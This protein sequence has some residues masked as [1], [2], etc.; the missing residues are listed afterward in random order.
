MQTAATQAA[1]IINFFVIK[2]SL[3][4]RSPNFAANFALARPLELATAGDLT[5]RLQ[6]LD[7][8]AQRTE[9]VTAV[10]GD[11]VRAP[12]RIPHPV[13]PQL[14]DQTRADQRVA[15]LVLDDVG[16]RAGRRRQRHVDQRDGPLL[17]F[18][19]V[20]TVDQAQVNDV[21]AEFGVDDIAHRLLDVAKQLVVR[22]RNFAHPLT[23]SK[24]PLACA[25]ASLN[26]IQPNS[27][28]FT[29]A[30]YFAT[31]ANATPSPSTSSSPAIFPRD[32]TI[33][34]NAVTVFSACPTLCPI[35]CSVSTDVAAWLIEQ[36]WPS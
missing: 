19:E 16:Q 24:S 13:D 11:L 34:V 8:E 29:R 10:F 4:V 23:S 18:F 36:P 31:P 28:H 14:I 3:S 17:R 21:D 30:G 33:P 2:R 12:R 7:S 25:S 15:R 32:D 26:A 1:T 5:G 35:T 27:A 9:L 6:Q 22:R 20:D